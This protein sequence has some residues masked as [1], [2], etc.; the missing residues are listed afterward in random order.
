MGDR[1]NG[2]HADDGIGIGDTGADISFLSIKAMSLP[3]L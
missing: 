3:S 2:V 1:E